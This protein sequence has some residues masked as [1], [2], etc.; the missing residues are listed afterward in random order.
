MNTYYISA[1]AMYRV[2]YQVEAETEDDAINEVEYGSVEPISSEFDGEVTD[3]EV[4]DVEYGETEYSGQLGVT[5]VVRGNLEEQK[6]VDALYSLLMQ[7]DGKTTDYGDAEL[8]LVGFSV[9]H[10]EEA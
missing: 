3:V 7:F 2:E 9:E 4:T 8:E 6:A 5:F 10:V 1:R